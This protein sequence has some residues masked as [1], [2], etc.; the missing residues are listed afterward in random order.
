MMCVHALFGEREI[1]SCSLQ[2]GGESSRF[3][4]YSCCDPVQAASTVAKLLQSHVHS[5]KGDLGYVVCHLG[6][7][8]MG[9]SLPTEQGA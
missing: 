8:H 5:C 9:R 4:I 6:F 7:D 1:M 3:G 2:G